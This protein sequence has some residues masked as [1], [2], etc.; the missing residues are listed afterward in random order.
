MKPSKQKLNVSDKW[1][2]LLDRD[3]VLIL[4]TETTGF[5]TESEIVEIAII[6]TKGETLLD[7]LV[8][9]EGPVPTESSAIHGLTRGCLKEGNAKPWPAHH[10]LVSAL[11]TRSKGL[12]IYNADYDVSMIER[13]RKRYGLQF[14][15][16][17]YDGDLVCVMRDYARYRGEYTQY[18]DFRWHKLEDAYRYETGMRLKSSHRALSDCQAVLGLM[19]SVVTNV[20]FGTPC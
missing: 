12:A 6:N 16:S 7:V 5:T 17:A 10:T 13:A 2:A 14:P 18:G 8:M 19:R 1:R 4:D 11:L 3:D 9:P 15:R 20:A